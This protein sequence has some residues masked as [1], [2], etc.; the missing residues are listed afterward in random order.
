MSTKNP[1]SAKLSFRNEGETN[2]IQD[3]QKLT[4]CVVSRSTL[5]ETLKEVL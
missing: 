5:E 1:M 2:T 4:G 3:K